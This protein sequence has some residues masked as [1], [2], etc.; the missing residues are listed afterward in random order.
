MDL[1]EI[2]Q[3]IRQ[4]GDHWDAHGAKQGKHLDDLQTQMNQIEAKINRAALSGGI[5]G[6]PKA[7]REQ[8]IDVKSKRPIDVMAATDLLVDLEDKGKAAPDLGRFLRGVVLGSRADDARELAQERKDM[9]IN[10]DPS[11]GYMVA[12]TLASQWIDL[13]RA[14]TVLVRAGARTVPM[15]SNSLTI[16]RVDADPTCS[17]HGENKSIPEV[18]PTLGAASLGAKTVVCLVKLSLELSQ[19]SANIEQLLRSVITSSMALEIDTA[20][21]VGKSTDAAAAPSGILGAKGRNTVTSIGAPTSWD[22]VVDGMYELLLDNVPADA[23]GALVAHPA[24]WKKMRKL[25]TGIASDNTPLTAPAEVAALPKFW[26]TAAPLTGGNTATAFLADWRDLLFG[27]RK[28]I[29]VRVLTEAFMGSNLQVAL[30]AY[31]RCDFV[32]AREKSLVTLEGITV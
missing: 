19:D 17:W 16:A 1:T 8:W 7:P 11:G 25:K 21:L 29:N 6:A 5:V 24:L 28:E 9:A 10:E 2:A 31:A 15:D 20:G 22:F 27:V 23:I 4:Q 12:G 13:L 32:L 26:T 18:K 14:Q 30:L 3:L